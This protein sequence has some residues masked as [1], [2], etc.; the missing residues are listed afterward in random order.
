MNNVFRLGCTEIVLF[1]IKFIEDTYILLTENEKTVLK[2]SKTNYIKWF[3]TTSGFYDKELNYS[4]ENDFVC[5]TDFNDNINYN[6]YWEIVLKNIKRK[7][8]YT[9]I[10]DYIIPL[11]CS[12]YK[13]DFIQMLNSE[14]NMIDTEPNIDMTKYYYNIIKKQNVLIISSFN[15][16]IC[17]QINNGNFYYLAN[18]LLQTDDYT[19]GN[20]TCLNTEYTFFNN[21]PESNIYDTFNRYLKA[22]EDFDDESYKVILISAGAYSVLFYDYFYDKNKVIIILGGQIQQLFGIVNQRY[23]NKQHLIE[24]HFGY[25]YNADK[26]YLITKIDNKYKPLNYE[27]I[28]GGCY[29]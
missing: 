21:G 12:L 14:S 22:I 4:I 17:S 26:K 25:E 15:E 3:Y 29:W 27:K 19:L 8:K 20:V 23:K 11:E 5:I 7:C 28:E 1:Y 18:R 6:K 13:T 24:K 10:K 9:P 16:L 2:Q